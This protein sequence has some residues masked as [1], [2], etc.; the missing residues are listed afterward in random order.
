LVR[1]RIKI[2]RTL[3]SLVRVSG[4]VASRSKRQGWQ[5]TQLLRRF[6]LCSIVTLIVLMGMQ[7]VLGQFPS[8]TNPTG[9]LTLPTGVER[10]GTLETAE[11]R[12][13]GEELFEIAS[14]AVFDRSQ[15]GNQIPVE[16]RAKQIEANLKQL[17]EDSRITDEQMLE[18]NKLEVAIETLNGLPVLF[19]KDAALAEAR[20]L[21]T[22]TDTDAQ[23][24]SIS[25]ERLANRWREILE[26]E[27]RQALELRQPEALQQQ[28]STVVKIGL[29]TVLL[30]LFLSRGWIFWRW[31]RQQLERRQVTQ[32][33]SART[34]EIP[35]EENDTEHRL[36]LFE[37]LRHY[38]G[39]QR[40]L[41]I[42][43]FLQ[44]LMFWAIAFVWVFG[45]AYSLYAFPQTR[46]FADTLVAIPIV[47]LMTWF[48]TGLMN[49]LTDLAI[50]RFI[51]SREQDRSLTEANLQRIATIANV[52]KGLK[53]A[54]IYTVGILWVLQWLKLVTGSILA[55]GAL[56]ALAVSFAA[57][58]LVKDLV[59]GFLILLE[60]QF[61]IG[62]HVKIGTAAGKVENLN[63]RITQLRTDDGNLITLPNSS[64]VQVENMSRTWARADFRVEVAYNTNVDLA[65]TVVRETVDRMA[66]E[67]EWRTWILDTHE[68]FGVDRISH[69]G[70]VIRIWIKTV[71][72]KQW[73]TA[74]EL[75]KTIISLCDATDRTSDYICKPCNPGNKSLIPPAINS[76]A[77]DMVINPIIL[78]MI[79]IPVLP[80]RLSIS[81]AR[82]N[83]MR[84]SKAMIVIEAPRARSLYRILPCWLA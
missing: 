17:I 36:T 75:R 83:V 18:P 42:A 55:L 69:T 52:I 39:I 12:L 76:T 43:R 16:V 4:R 61:R 62:D 32:I 9:T 14:P 67:P 57:Q 13:D 2:D 19:V 56:V 73:I 65:L 25:K 11:V 37:G 27:L 35:D 41:E 24:Y 59:N 28:V 3:S 26:S 38:F 33:A 64:I 45:V 21:L 8:L 30:T 44:W 63:L 72:L 70:I 29:A 1:G 50:D 48:L 51:Q 47:I 66:R 54:L 77:I 58:S 34:E 68:L 23:Y 6:V 60:D 49:R 81:G 7:P 84:I 78:A 15:L 22:V 74:R 40:R 20:V 80:M 46:Q 79:F 82:V 31:R 10:R 71:P 5:R 53:M